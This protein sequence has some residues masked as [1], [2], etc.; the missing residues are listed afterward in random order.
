[1]RNV[2]ERFWCILAR[3]LPRV[4]VTA[5]LARVWRE[6]APAWDGSDA[7]EDDRARMPFRIAW[8]RWHQRAGRWNGASISRPVDCPACGAPL[9]AW[10]NQTV[11]SRETR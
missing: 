8:R 6:T 10:A 1:M 7:T 9:S 11:T 2:V 4:L 3:L 5:A